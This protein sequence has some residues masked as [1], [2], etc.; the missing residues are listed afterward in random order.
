MGNMRMPRMDPARGRKLFAEK[1]CVACHAINGVGG[2]DAT[3]LD[4]HT[5]QSMMNPFDFAA[6]M[7]R[8]APYMI[9]A[10]EEAIGEMITFSGDELA[11]ITAFVHHEAEQHKF[12][13]A[14]IPPRVKAMMDH[15]HADPT[16][17]KPKGGA[18]AHQD[19]IGHGMKKKGHEHE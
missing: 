7:W 15:E 6:K 14:D 5:M 9:A 3:P 19:E 10:Q 12:S 2:H 18:D 16:G 1:G 17:G 11:A 13:A 4:A 8:M